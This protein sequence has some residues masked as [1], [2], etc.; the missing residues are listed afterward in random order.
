MSEGK[1]G[2]SLNERD[3][4]PLGTDILKCLTRGENL[5]GSCRLRTGCTVPKWRKSSS[6]NP[7]VVTH[8]MPL[9][10]PNEG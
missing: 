8:P 9:A 10:I 7:P 6:R 2:K 4:S 5:Y 3:R 1:S